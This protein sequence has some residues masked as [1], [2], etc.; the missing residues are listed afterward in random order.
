MTDERWQLAYKIYETA[1]PLAEPNRRQYVDAAAP[2]E[3]IAAKVL[4]ML[5][6]MGTITD[7]DVFPGSASSTDTGCRG[8][9]GLQ[10]PAERRGARSFCHHRFCRARGN[11][12]SLFCSRPR[13]EPRSCAESDRPKARRFQLR[14]VHS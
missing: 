9:F 11:G 10:R 13:P 7:P 12:Q 5:D 2:D 6:E 1:A 14:T 4:A 8:R 3:E